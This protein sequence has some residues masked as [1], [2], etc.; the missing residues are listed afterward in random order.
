MSIGGGSCRYLLTAGSLVKDVRIVS[1]SY[2]DP[3]AGIAMIKFPCICKN[4]L[5]VP[6][7]LAG[8]LIQCPRCGRL[9]DVPT[10]SDLEHLRD[11]GTIELLEDDPPASPPAEQMATYKRVYART[12]R[13]DSGAEIDLRPTPEEIALAGEVPDEPIPVHRAPKYDPV[14]GELIRPLDIKQDSDQPTGPIPVAKAAL[15][16]S[17]DRVKDALT[18]ARILLELFMPLNMI[19]MFFVYL[20]HAAAQALS[21]VLL[22]S[23]LN[24]PISMVIMAHYASVVESTG[25]DGHDELPR[26]L[27]DASFSEDLWW[28]LVQMFFSLGLTLGPVLFVLMWNPIPDGLRTPLSI[29]LALMGV[30]FLPAVLLTVVTGATMLNLRPDRVLG[31]MWACGWDY[32]VSILGCFGVLGVYFAHI[33]GYHLLPDAW[34]TAHPWLNLLRHPSVEYTTLGIAVYLGH[35]FTWHL[36]MLYRRHHEKFPWILQRHIPRPKPAPARRPPAHLHKGPA[37]VDPTLG[38]P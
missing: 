7:E 33:L 3:N 28:P 6:E 22:L 25:P 34:I 38:H 8:G 30:V 14:T 15:T 13:D 17:T 4:E 23:I 10:L 20:L 36:G 27:R 26:P 21:S 11:D 5:E 1:G 24:I 37:E 9:N 12:T 29:V 2:N 31:V 19:V 18:P 16:Y 35:F 32:G